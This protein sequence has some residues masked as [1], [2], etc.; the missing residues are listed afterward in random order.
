MFGRRYTL[1]LNRVHDSIRIKEGN[2]TL[3]LTV[4][5]DPMRMV[6]ALNKAQKSL[7]GV[8]DNS[9]E[10]DIKSAA[11]M[12]ASAIFGDVQAHQIMEFY[13]DDA[14]CVINLCG[15]YFADRLSGIIT[16]V[17]KRSK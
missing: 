1:S 9:N 15:R 6:A 16:K 5:A 11:I 10:E 17:Q 8:N 14:G 13:H 2:D 4:D 7:K 3:D 12:F